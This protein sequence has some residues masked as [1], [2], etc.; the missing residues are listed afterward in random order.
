MESI[1]FTIADSKRW[2]GSF[3]QNFEQEGFDVLNLPYQRIAIHDIALYNMLGDSIEEDENGYI[4]ADI[5]FRAPDYHNYYAKDT[6][7]YKRITTPLTDVKAFYKGEEITTPT[8][9]EYSDEIEVY[10]RFDDST[11]QIPFDELMSIPLEL[12]NATSGDTFAYSNIYYITKYDENAPEGYYTKYYYAKFTVP[13]GLGDYT[14]DLASSGT[15]LLNPTIDNFNPFEISVVQES[16]HGETPV[17]L[18]NDYYELNYGDS[19][20]LEGAVLDNDEYIVEDEVYSYKWQ[21]AIDGETSYALDIVSP[22]NDAGFISRD[23]FAIY[24]ITEDLEKRPLYVNLNGEYYRKSEILHETKNPHINYVDNQFILTTHWNSDSSE[25]IQYDTNLLITYKVLKGKPI[26]PLSYSR[27]D[28]FGNSLYDNLIEIPFAKYDMI[29][30]EWITEQSITETFSIQPELLYEET[31][32][33][34]IT[35]QGPQYDVDGQTIRL[36]IISCEHAQVNKSGSMIYEEIAP[37]NYTATINANG[38][39]EFTYTQ[40][41]SGDE[42][43]IGYYS[44]LPIELLHPLLDTDLDWIRM[45]E[46]GNMSHY[47]EFSTEEYTIAENGYMV[48]F[49]DLYNDLALES[50]E[51]DIYDLLNIKYN[52]TYTKRVDL[53]SNLIIMLQNENADYIPIDT[54]PI[55][56]LGFFEYDTL[57]RKDQLSLPLGGKTVNNLK[58]TYLPNQVFN[59]SKQGF[60]PISYG[61]ENTYIYP[62][63]NSSQW[64]TYFRIITQGEKTK[65]QMIGYETQNMVVSQSFIEER[66]YILN[67]NPL[68]ALEEGEEYSALSIDALVREEYQ[69]NFKLT[70]W[71]DKPIQNNIVWLHIGFMPKSRTGFINERTIMD[72]GTKIYYESLGTQELTSIGPGDGPRKMFGRPLTY[73]IK[74]PNTNSSSYGPYEWR[75]GLTDEFGE[76]SFDITFDEDYLMHFADIFGSIE[77]IS[78]I[79]DMVL[80]IRAFS[81]H[82]EWDEMRIDTPE[83]YVCSSNEHVFNGT[84]IIEDYEFEQLVLQDPTYAEGL[85]RLHRKDIALGI[86][87]YLT[88][89]LPDEDNPLPDGLEP[90]EINIYAQEATPIPT[91]ITKTIDSLT[92]QYSASSL[93]ALSTSIFEDNHSYYAYIDFINPN[94]VNVRNYTT[95]YM[96]D[97]T[98]NGGLIT[99]TNDTMAAIIND[100]GPGLSTIRIQ[101]AESPYYKASPMMNIPLE[102]KPANWLKFGEK[103]TKIDLLDPFISSWGTASHNEA[104]MPFESNYPV[105]SGAFWIAPFFNASGDELSVQD[106]IE[107]NL[108]CTIYNDDGSTSTFPLRSD[109]MLRAG[110]RDGIMTFSEY[111]GPESAFLMGMRCDLNLSFSIDYSKEA[112]YEEQRDVEITLLDLRLEANPSSTNPKTY[113][114]LF[115][116]QFSSPTDNVSVAISDG[117]TTESNTLSLGGVMN[118]ES[119]GQPIAFVFDNETESFGIDEENAILEMLALTEITPL[120]VMGIKDGNEH[121]FST[122][123]WDPVYPT[124]EDFHNQSLIQFTT[125]HPDEGTEFE[126]YYQLDF[127]FTS[128]YYGTMQL[129]PTNE[130]NETSIQL[131]LVE[132]FLP[133]SNESESAMYI[134]FEHDCIGDG[135]Q[136]AFTMEY[137]LEGVSQWDD[138]YFVIYNEDELHDH[139]G[140]QDKTI[141]SG[142]PHIIFATAPENNQ[143]F[144]IE[145][146]VKSAYN[147]GFGFQ[148][149][150]KR[151]SDSVR[152]MS[153]NNESSIPIINSDSLQMDPIQLDDPSLYIDLDEPNQTTTLEILSVPLLFAP[154][155]NLTFTMDEI[156]T[157]YISTFNGDFNNLTIEFKYITNDGYYEFVSDPY[158]LPLN[159]TEMWYD[160]DPEEHNSYYITYQKDLNAI[161]EMVGADTVDIVITISQQGESNHTI[162][163]IILEQCDYLTDS[164]FVEMYD[165]KPLDKTGDFNTRSAINT[166]HYFQILS[167]PFRDSEAYPHFPDSPYDLMENSKITIGLKDLP[168][169]TLVQLETMGGYEFTDVGDSYTIDVNDANYNMIN[170]LGFFTDLYNID[171]PIYQ[172]GYIDLYYGSGTEI[173]GSKIY[174]TELEM[175]PKSSIGNYYSNSANSPTAY[176]YSATSW[177]STFDF[178]TQFLTTD[179]IY[180]SGEVF[181]HHLIDMTEDVISAAQMNEMF[182]N[183]E[184][185]I[186]FGVELPSYLDI[187]EIDQ[188]G[189]PYSY[190]LSIQGFP[191]GEN[192][193]KY[194]TINTGSSFGQRGA[195]QLEASNYALEQL[196]N[197]SIY[198]LFFTSESAVSSYADADNFIMVDLHAETD[199]V[200]TQDYEIQ[201]DPYDPWTSQIEWTY[202]YTDTDNFALHPDFSRDANFS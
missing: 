156:I 116:D 131:D 139:Y 127:D 126:I 176:T 188:I 201:E 141:S 80:Y 62:Y 173:D 197:G 88:Y 77:G 180:V 46:D 68:E 18:E 5:E 2:P 32:Q 101:I 65:L 163:Y 170:N 70:D 110:N 40:Y 147:I 25:F 125:A 79:E 171:E 123:E 162:P 175:T 66:K 129:G 143:E 87:D 149:V 185:N 69:F 97:E 96:I 27:T 36:G 9:V 179:E 148:K 95:S 161:Y 83:E 178:A 74:Y 138:E 73:W 4:T 154:E 107:I 168:N 30:N 117:F 26:T 93:E 100:L 128:G 78:S 34:L 135:S 194:C 7:R 92:Q 23:E 146:G 28:Q 49:H 158:I 190:D 35:I 112:I 10:F 22:Y 122:F 113:W 130:I 45:Y 3:M 133:P 195:A 1:S 17:Y 102:I 85:I 153:N 72:D 81:S 57:F 106:Y 103:N 58:L 152:L 67:R 121:E 53:A 64:E 19:L 39:L 155:L 71:N 75:Y 111:L 160:L 198:I 105:F 11:A 37:E 13:Q 21:E 104:E 108:D 48:Y 120:K 151:F 61:I 136:T 181:Y 137:G 94:G 177:Q 132:G 200:E 174:T 12:V 90:I 76:V 140:I 157:D 20:L 89:D 98:A 119:Y 142:R 199:F 167:K 16:L 109:I 165:R 54:I 63:Q 33:Q 31:D 38:E 172:Q 86:S 144:L 124:S 189:S 164:H 43:R 159:Y 52:T 114:S 51:F 82:F 59:L 55:D 192:S 41:Q 183:Y 99:I 44:Y 60:D 186:Q 150:G 50:S 8:N 184:Q 91:G 115:E 134:R 42:I 29:A 166:P 14:L 84:N 118:G 24:Y 47:Y 187:T 193:S 196:W 56:T 6:F 169:S 191:I 145:Y 182:D 202:A 15:V